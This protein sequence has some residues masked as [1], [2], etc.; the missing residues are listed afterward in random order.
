MW[1][2]L[3]RTI[4]F[5]KSLISSYFLIL[6]VQTSTPVTFFFFFFSWGLHGGHL[7]PLLLQ[8]VL[9]WWHMRLKTLPYNPIFT[10]ACLTLYE[11]AKTCFVS[12][13]CKITFWRYH[14]THWHSKEWKKKSCVPPVVTDKRLLFGWRQYHA[15][16][17]NRHVC[18]SHLHSS[19]IINSVLTNFAQSG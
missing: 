14:A 3:R 5:S 18:S 4:W 2:Y 12:V 11:T 10:T 15:F 9:T 19:R 17:Y 7:I 13:V 6:N 8:D 1:P 16:C